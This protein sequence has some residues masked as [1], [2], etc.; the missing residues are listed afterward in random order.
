LKLDYLGKGGPKMGFFQKLFFGEYDFKTES[1]K[2]K[3]MWAETSLGPK[4][5]GP[6]GDLQ[7]KIQENIGILKYL[8]ACTKFGPEKMKNY[9]T[10]AEKIGMR[11]E[12]E[13]KQQMLNAKAYLM[14]KRESNGTVLDGFEQM[15]ITFIEVHAGTVTQGIQ[16]IKTLSPKQATISFLK[17]VTNEMQ[18]LTAQVKSGKPII[19]K[20]SSRPSPDDQKK[21]EEYFKMGIRCDNSDD[22]EGAINHYSKAINL[23]K[24]PMAFYYRACVYQDQKKY[25]K[26]IQDFKSY[27]KYGPSNT[28]EAIASRV[29]I[30]ELERKI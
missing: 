20:K 3:E 17:N 16:T 15:K 14:P 1:E 27:L 7:T 18:E 28:K 26:A 30:E 11:F 25:K 24:H 22:L 12:K 23:N 8:C 9:I 2:K 29:S 6:A 21:G 19:K 4:L 10:M 13:E 5:S